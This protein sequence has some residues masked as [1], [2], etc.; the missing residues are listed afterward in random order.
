MWA[1]RADDDEAGWFARHG[2]VPPGYLGDEE[3]TPTN[4]P[5]VD[6]RRDSVPG[7]RARLMDTGLAEPTHERST[8][9]DRVQT[10]LKARAVGRLLAQR[11]R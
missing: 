1:L 10:D 3:K 9:Q 7:D 2:W 11:L 4:F 8:D 5:A 6:G